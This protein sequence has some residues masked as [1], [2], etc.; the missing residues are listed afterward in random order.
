VWICSV[1]C[2]AELTASARRG[3]FGHAEEGWG[4]KVIDG[5]DAYA[6]I[7]GRGVGEMIVD[8][9]FDTRSVTGC[10]EDESQRLNCVVFPG[11]G[12]SNSGTSGPGA[13][14]GM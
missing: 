8:V 3:K 1:G 14:A 9:G 10:V 6:R 12:A 13:L 11:N 4:R 2:S 7:D 5:D